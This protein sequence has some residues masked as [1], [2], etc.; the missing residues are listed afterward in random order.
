MAWFLPWRGFAGARRSGSHGALEG[1]EEVAVFFEGFELGELL[2]DAGRGVEEESVVGFKEHGG[3]VEGVAGG[4]N[5]IN[6]TLEGG[7]G[8]ALGMFLA[9]AEAGDA[10]V[11]NRQAMAEDVGH[12]SWRMDGLGEFLKG[13]GQDDDLGE[14]AQLAQEVEGRRGAGAWRR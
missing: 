13:V 3:V 4:E 5:L 10:A 2:A 14:G 1:G 11:N 6:A 12:S 7:D 8:A 9:E